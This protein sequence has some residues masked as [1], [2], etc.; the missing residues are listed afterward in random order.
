M[1]ANHNNNNKQ[2]SGSAT[3]ESLEKVARDAGL[4]PGK[5]VDYRK[6][7]Q[8]TNVEPLRETTIKPKHAKKKGSSSKGKATKSKDEKGTKDSPRGF[9]KRTIREEARCSFCGNLMTQSTKMNWH[10]L[11]KVKLPPHFKSAPG[12]ASGKASAVLCDGC[13]NAQ[14]P[15]DYK[16]AVVEREDDGTIVNVPVADLMV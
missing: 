12:A 4:D 2:E 11:D 14:P 3:N 15:R 16:T 6:V 5:V 1:T 7:D 10:P 13:E 8:G 9:T